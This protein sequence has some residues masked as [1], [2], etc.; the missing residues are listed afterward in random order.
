MMRW[1]T[2]LAI[3]LLMICISLHAQVE[4]DSLSSTPAVVDSVEQSPIVPFEK[5]TSTKVDTLQ[6]GYVSTKKP[7]LALLFSA[8][9]PGA[10]Q[11]YNESYWKIPIVLG[12]GSYFVYGWIHNNNLYKGYRDDFK[13]SLETNLSGN[14]SLL[15]LREFYKD[16]RDTFTWY[17]AILYLL[18]LV[19]AYVDAALY[20]F[21]V[22]GDLKLRM[23]PVQSGR[24][25]LLLS[26]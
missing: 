24:V 20:D 1:M 14:G 13:K 4:P 23:F 26:F 8:V 22:G 25:G 11:T 21:D 2:A 19:D 12:F 16:Q 6:R 5:M 7:G 17:F 18:N 9:L 3:A 10:G 15:R